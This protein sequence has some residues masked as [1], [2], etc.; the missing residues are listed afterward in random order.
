[1]NYSVHSIQFGLIEAA[2]NECGHNGI[3]RLKTI[4]KLFRIQCTHNDIGFSSGEKSVCI[5]VEWVVGKSYAILNIVSN[6]NVDL[7]FNVK[8]LNLCHLHQQLHA[9]IA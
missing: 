2:S 9:I 8:R 1:M 3:P 6:W 5:I 4:L 7:L